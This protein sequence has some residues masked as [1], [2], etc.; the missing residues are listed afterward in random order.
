MKLPNASSA[1]VDR[2]KVHDYLLSPTHQ[3]GRFKATFFA[4]LGYS[5]GNCSDL[6]RDLLKIASDGQGAHGKFSRFGNK[7]EVSGMLTGPLGRSANVLT[8]WI[9]L[10]NEDFPRFVTAMPGN[11]Q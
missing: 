6:E 4:L 10:H 7:Y 1:V 3:V 8:V 9:V 11:R 2:E 5:Q